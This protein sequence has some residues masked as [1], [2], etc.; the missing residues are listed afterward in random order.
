MSRLEQIRALIADDPRD[1]MLRFAL[2]N[3]LF[4]LGRYVEAIEPLK[5]ALDIDPEYAF[6]YIQLAQAYEQSG[7]IELAWQT[8]ESGR[9]PAARNGDPNLMRQLDAI[10]VRL[11][12]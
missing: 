11:R 3:E 6:V 5:A 12:G 8:V 9:G 7:Q 10:A 4:Q 2:G 1:A